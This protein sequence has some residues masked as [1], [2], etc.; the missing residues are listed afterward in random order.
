MS[1]S[2]Q[3]LVS[4]VLEMLVTILNEVPS[5]TDGIR[6]NSDRIM[7]LM[8][9][10]LLA[11]SDLATGLMS[12]IMNIVSPVLDLGGAVV[13]IT[14]N[15]TANVEDMVNTSD[16]A[17]VS[18]VAVG[19]N[20]TPNW[21]YHQFMDAASE[22]LPNIIGPSDGSY[23]LTYILN[24]TTYVLEHDVEAYNYIG[25]QLAYSLFVAL[26]EIINLLADF[27]LNI[28][29]TFVWAPL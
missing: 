16:V 21:A 18:M 6:K 19:G 25:S 1:V 2:I 11:G 20:G 12:S 17:N 10:L 3:S 26:T 27:M 28:N 7:D 29:E 22:G 23:G 13:N 8:G 5:I 15:S 14:T 4:N 9:G 24:G